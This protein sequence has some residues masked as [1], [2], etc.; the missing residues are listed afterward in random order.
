MGKRGKKNKQ[1]ARKA[2]Q[3]LTED[4]QPVP[5]LA[6]TAK[7]GL[8]VSNAWAAIDAYFERIWNSLPLKAGQWYDFAACL[9]QAK[10]AHHDQALREYVDLRL[11]GRRRKLKL[12]GRLM[13]PTQEITDTYV[14]MGSAHPGL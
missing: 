8:E 14:D 4:I 9:E 12:H 2:A 13:R 7:A 5:L 10:A 3:V 1:K 6:D 11:Q